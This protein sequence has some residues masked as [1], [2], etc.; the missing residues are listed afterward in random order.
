MSNEEEREIMQK[1]SFNEELKDNTPNTTINVMAV[2]FNEELKVLRILATVASIFS[3]SFNEELKVN[4]VPI[5]G[6]L[7]HLYPLMRN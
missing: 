6:F 4:P 1:V 5:K 2:S 3:V 7:N